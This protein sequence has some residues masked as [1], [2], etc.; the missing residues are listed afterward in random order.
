[1][2]LLPVF[3]VL[4]RVAAKV[5][6]RVRFGG[7]AVPAMGPVLLVANHPN[8]LLD[9]TL[10]VASADRPVRFLAKA[11]LFA[12]PK[13]AWLM[14]AAGA[15]PVYRR[16]DD[17]TQMDR[18]EDAF[19]AVFD[20][21]GAGSA[22]GIFPEGIS[23]SQPAMAPL[24][25]GAARIALGASHQI[26]RPFPIVPIGLTFRAK[27]V[28]RSDALVIRGSPVAWED[29]AHRGTAD[30]D[31]VRELTGRIDAAL[32]TITVNLD[33]WEDHPVV[34]CAVRIWEAE[35]GEPSREA[36]RI[37]RLEFTTRVL[38]HIRSTSDAKGLELL[39]DVRHFD[40]RLSGLG[41]KPADLVADISAGRGIGWAVRRIHL[42]L[43]I[44]AGLAAVGAALFWVPY[45]LTGIVV[46]RLRL[47]ADVRSTWKLLVGIVLYVLWLLALTLLAGATFG[48]LGALLTV[49]LVPL[50]AMA[51]LA[52][53]EGWRF[54]WNDARRFFLLR[55]R[56]SLVARLRDEQ[57]RLADRLDALASR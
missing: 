7:A 43:P 51:G 26:G 57:K 6:Y 47:P 23:H 18:N 19:R 36:E 54:A 48:W 32:R 53:R 30:S 2:W 39:A 35:R 50:V 5:Y 31:A 12:D 46:N 44:G 3:S 13:I 29:L 56:G 20:A 17:P 34:E 45:Q 55:S 10:V 4:A 22:V 14:K 33:S 21:L 25:T 52:V 40:R 37:A 28:F 11:P 8:S 24:K 49:V 41:L 27:D 16:S 9:P 1:M 42:L 38:A 15:I